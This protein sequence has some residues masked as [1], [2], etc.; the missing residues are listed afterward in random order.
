MD[1]EDDKI[2][3]WIEGLI[4]E[5]F[6]KRTNLF[7][8]PLI[9]FSSGDDVLYSFFKQHIG[10]FYWLP[11]EAF[12]LKYPNESINDC[13]ISV[14]SIVL[15]QT[16]LTKTM[17]LKEKLYPSENWIDSRLEF[18]RLNK[19]MAMHLIDEFNKAGYKA[20][21][22]SKLKQWRNHI[23]EKH[24]Y[25]SS[26]SERHTAFVS[27]LGTFGLCDGL[28]TEKG[29]AH[30]CTSIIINT[31]LTPTKRKY[32]NHT[33][34]CLFYSGIG[35]NKCIE[36][37]PAG[38][39]SING[40][41]KIKCRQYTREVTSTHTKKAYNKDSSSCGLCQTDVPCESQIPVNTR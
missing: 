40:H 29:K 19:N 13:D 24:I 4:G 41:D 21:V 17:Q 15:P 7:A 6:T 10:D 39:I 18:N 22:P 9:G 31:K 12:L 20:L 8:K 25:A 3:E 23:T 14:I 2:I 32:K 37:C 27:G 16:S 11:K 33:E 36:R 34:Y 28:I 30:R 35:C 1:K 26:W 38:A 5:F